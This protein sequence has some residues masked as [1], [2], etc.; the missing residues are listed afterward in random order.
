LS[1]KPSLPR[2]RSVVV[3]A[4]ARTGDR[5][6]DDAIGAAGA[7]DT[8]NTAVRAGDGCVGRAGASFER[9]TVVTPP[10]RLVRDASTAAIGCR[11]CVDTCECRY[12]CAA[13]ELRSL[14]RSC[15]RI[16]AA[17][18][19]VLATASVIRRKSVTFRRTVFISRSGSVIN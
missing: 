9:S 7:I 4:S 2:E 12:V 8:G 5:F 15:V 14:T 18:A 1:I 11:G 13:V 17:I 19:S 10:L 3:T 16:G 6:V